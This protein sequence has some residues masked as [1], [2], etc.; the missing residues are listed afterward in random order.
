MMGK[1][2]TIRHQMSFCTGVR[3]DFK[4]STVPDQYLMFPETCKVAW[5]MHE[6]IPKT[7]MSRM[8][9]TSPRRPPPVPYC[10]LLSRDSVETGAA[11]PRV[12]SPSWR[13]MLKKR[14]LKFMMLVC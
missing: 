2:K 4:T 12:A 5:V 10:Q 1:R 7:I 11:R 3:L 14:V 8:R 13:R 9:T 6:D